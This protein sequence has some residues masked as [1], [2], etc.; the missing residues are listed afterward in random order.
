MGLLWKIQIYNS[1]SA[2]LEGCI[3]NNN[4]ILKFDV[5]LNK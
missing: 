4:W 1:H 5:L 2:I 3:R